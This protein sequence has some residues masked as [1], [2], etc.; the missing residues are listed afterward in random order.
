M[1][2]HFAF[3]LL[4]L[5][6]DV[7][8]RVET[9]QIRSNAD[10]YVEEIIETLRGFG[11]SNSSTNNKIYLESKLSA[12]DHR[13]IRNDLAKAGA[14]VSLSAESWDLKIT[15][16]IKPNNALSYIQK[17]LALRKIE[18]RV[19]LMVLKSDSTLFREE[20]LLVNRVDTLQRGDVSYVIGNFPYQR[21]QT[22]QPYRHKLRIWLEPALV[23][24]GVGVSV[25]LLFNIRGS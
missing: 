22:V 24:V 19:E 11:L 6:P 17:N 5:C 7:A 20:R 8:L 12:E 25:F 14:S 23:I 9:R 10:I 3:I 15:I 1:N 21:F 13:E 2:L 16:F 18:G 4:F